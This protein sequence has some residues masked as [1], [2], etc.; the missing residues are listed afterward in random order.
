LWPAVASSRTYSWI[1]GDE[2]GEVADAARR[3]HRWRSLIWRHSDGAFAE[4]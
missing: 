3:G 4:W 2:A 1:G